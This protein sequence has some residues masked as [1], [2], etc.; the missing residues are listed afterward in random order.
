MSRLE[1]HHAELLER[2]LTD[3]Q[4]LPSN[5]DGQGLDALLSLAGELQRQLNPSPASPAVRARV[6]TRLMNQL[7]GK[8]RQAAWQ[9]PSFPLAVWLRRAVVVV[10]AVGLVAGLTGG[11]ALAAT[12]A[13]PGEALYPL[14]LAGESLQLAIS[15]SDEQDAALL[16]HFTEVRLQE[17]KHLL[18]AGQEDLAVRTLQHYDSSMADLMVAVSGL[19]DTSSVEP[20]RLALGRQ[21]K[22]VLALL[23]DAPPTVVS[24]L[25]RAALHAAQAEAS[26]S[27]SEQNPQREPGKPP[28]AVDPKRT[29]P[30]QEAKAT[31]PSG[32]G[33]VKEHGPKDKRTATPAPPAP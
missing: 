29:P 30:G 8:R 15:P 12:H 1:V 26:L 33:Q 18:A 5:T 2:A 14:K 6:E 19:R 22:A 25:E 11:T 4:P 28:K 13:L 31:K 20:T 24:A 17:T 7:R 21:R 3:G 23:A 27:S 16:L 9:P 32:R 10:L